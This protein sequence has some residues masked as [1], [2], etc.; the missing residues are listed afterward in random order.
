MRAEERE[1]F[2]LYYG[3]PRALRSNEAFPAT[4]RRRVICALPCRRDEISGGVRF[5]MGFK[6][7]RRL[8]R[9]EFKGYLAF[10][11]PSRARA[12]SRQSC[13]LSA[14]ANGIA[15][16]V[17]FLPAFFFFFFFQS[18]QPQIDRSRLS[19]VRI[20]QRIVELEATITLLVIP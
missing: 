17:F 10:K 4:S 2:N 18:F 13:R 15:V 5:Q 6:I 9:R 12:V 20:W 3:S 16:R 7:M 14:S 8:R 1:C 11:G 19:L